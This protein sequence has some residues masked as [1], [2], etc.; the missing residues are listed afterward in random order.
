[1]RTYRD[2]CDFQDGGRRHVGFSKIQILTVDPLPW[3][4]MRHHAKFHQNLPNGGGYM[5]I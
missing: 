3:A 1:L 2:F 5:A 4:K